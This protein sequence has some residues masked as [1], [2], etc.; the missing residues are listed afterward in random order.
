MTSEGARPTTWISPTCAASCTGCTPSS[1]CT[2][3]R[4]TRPTCPSVTASKPGRQPPGE[5]R[6]APGCGYSR[7]GLEG[8]VGEA[9]PERQE[10]SGVGE[11]QPACCG[12]ARSAAAP[13][14]GGRACAVV[15]LGPGL[16]TAGGD[17]AA[18]PPVL[19]RVDLAASQPLVQY[20][21]RRTVPAPPATT[22]V[23]P[24]AGPAR[25]A[26]DQGEDAPDEQ[27]PEREH[28]HPHQGDLPPQ[29]AAAVPEHHRDHLL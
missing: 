23:L 20:G 19:L 1:A 4:K 26:G 11:N 16:L 14:S 13:G 29:P 22:R 21:K 8:T 24:V 17:Q 2:P 18:E 25:G 7:R 10:A 12:L 27:A 5:P 3:P 6:E 15:G 28:A 9:E